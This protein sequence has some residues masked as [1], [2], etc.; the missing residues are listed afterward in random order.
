MSFWY[1]LKQKAYSTDKNNSW[2]KAYVDRIVGFLRNETANT[3]DSHF[4]GAANRHSASHIDTAAGNTVE[5][6]LG[7]ESIARQT[8]DESNNNKIT[9]ETT[10]R[11]AGDNNLS[12]R[13][14]NET[15]ERLSADSALTS[16][17]SVESAAREAADSSLTSSL[18]AETAA[19]EAADSE[20]NVKVS[21]ILSAIPIDT[22]TLAPVCPDG[23]PIGATAWTGTGFFCKSDGSRYSAN[24][25]VTSVSGF[26]RFCLRPTD[27]I[28]Y[29]KNW[30]P[31]FDYNGQAYEFFYSGVRGVYETLIPQT[32]M[33]GEEIVATLRWEYHPP[34]LINYGKI[35][36]LFGYIDPEPDNV[37]SHDISIYIRTE[38][39][40]RN[41]SGFINKS[42]FDIAQSFVSNFFTISSNSI[43]LA[44][45][46][47]V[48]GTIYVL[49]LDTSG[50]GQPK[51][52]ASI[53]QINKV[54]N[55]LANM[56]IETCD[57]F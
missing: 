53:I 26:N 57:K 43:A 21:R 24:T 51:S 17:I 52:A 7:I 18:L 28:P 49:T 8:A 22:P 9:Q 15:A 56:T 27:A 19:R 34:T 16:S 23:T 46:D 1:D 50:S 12:E 41:S 36:N 48:R 25:E 14:S 40:F 44:D 20:I 39:F 32:T 13:I 10:D 35:S 2:L 33:T 4:S 47:W 3:F 45:M 37:A 30:T 38:F 55:Q 54:Y 42:D 5:E 6:A 31:Y 11:I 29:W